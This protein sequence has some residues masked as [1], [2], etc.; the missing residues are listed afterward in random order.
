MN[1]RNAMLGLAAAP[2]A[3]TGVSFAQG[4]SAGAGAVGTNLIAQLFNTAGAPIGTF[5][6]QRFAAIGGQLV[7]LGTATITNGTGT[8]VTTLAQNV[9][10]SVNPADPPPGSCPIL[11][12]D[13][14]PITLNLLGLQIT[15]SEIVLDIVAISGPGNLLGNLLCGIAGLL[16][17]GGTLTNILNQLVASLNQLLG[18]L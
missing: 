4:G 18:S 3:A 2:L 17:P 9:T 16:N 11:H 15:T 13:I 7:A 8:L 12:L 10:P 5:A 14:A 6:I 1:R